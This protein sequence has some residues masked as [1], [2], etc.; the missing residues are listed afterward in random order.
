MLKDLQIELKQP[1]DFW[2]NWLESQT[3][4]RGYRPISFKSKKNRGIHCWELRP[5]HK[6]RIF[7]CQSRKC[8]NMKQFI[9]QDVS[10]IRQLQGGMS[11]EWQNKNN[12]KGTNFRLVQY[13]LSIFKI[14]TPLAAHSS[15]QN[16]TKIH[17]ISCRIKTHTHI[18]YIY[19]FLKTWSHYS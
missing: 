15:E 17:G 10:Y 5:A 11:V 12:A 3:T 18:L 2:E 1:S 7:R 4:K 16:A 9:R 13:N 14:G 19:F 8:S 6:T